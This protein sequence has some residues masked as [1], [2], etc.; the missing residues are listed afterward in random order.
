MALYCNVCGKATTLKYRLYCSK[1]CYEAKGPTVIKIEKKYKQD[2]KD[3][4]K[5]G[6]STFGT[7][8]ALADSLDVSNTAVH[9]WIKKY[10]VS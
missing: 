4:L 1:A 9:R 8:K 6:L 5:Q 7:V 3:V 2:I 10:K